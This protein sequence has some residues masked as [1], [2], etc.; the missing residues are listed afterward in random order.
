[1]YPIAS[2]R[3]S[4]LSGPLIAV[5]PQVTPSC[6]YPLVPNPILDLLLLQ[7]GLSSPSK[8]ILAFDIQSVSET[9]LNPSL[10]QFKCK[11]AYEPI[12]FFHVLRPS[13]VLRYWPS[14]ISEYRELARLLM[15]MKL[16]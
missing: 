1:M 13:E 8:P 2:M 10:L 14:A 7:L 16:I 3:L 9:T 5:F 6:G 4:P 11:E 12:S 15:T